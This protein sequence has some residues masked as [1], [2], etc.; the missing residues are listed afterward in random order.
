MSEITQIKEIMMQKIAY[1][2]N[3]KANL[4]EELSKKDK[5]I[6]D[7]THVNMKLQSESIIRESEL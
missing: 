2:S 1:I 3:E 5:R 6:S 7:L 4:N